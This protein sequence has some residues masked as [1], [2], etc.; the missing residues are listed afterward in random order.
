MSSRRSP[1]YKPLLLTTTMRNASRLRSFLA[2]LREFEGKVLTNRLCEEI[3]TELIR[4]GLYQPLIHSKKV[5]AKWESGEPLSLQEAL[6]VLSDNPQNHKEAGFDRGWPSR[7]DTHYKIAKWF[8]A[9]FYE[10]GSPITFSPLGVHCLEDDESIWERNFFTI[11]FANY[12]RSNPFQR[13]L[14]R[15]RPLLLLIETLSALREVEGSDSPGISRR[16]LPFLLCWQ[17]SYAADLASFILQIRESDGYDISD[18]RI[19]DICRGILEDPNY[20]IQPR[21][22]TADYSDEFL[23]K[24]RLTGLF[25]M[26]GHGRF[27]SLGKESKLD[28]INYLKANYSG[29]EDFVDE[30]SY[31]ESVSQFDETLLRLFHGDS[32]TPRSVIDDIQLDRWVLEF[33][34]ESIKSELALLARRRKSDDDLLRLIP[35]PLRLEFLSALRL[36]LEDKTLKVRPNYVSDDDGFPLSHAPGHNADIVVTNSAG[37]TYLLE[38]T[39]IT[40]GGQVRNEMVQITRHLQD[41]PSSRKTTL[42]VAPTIHTDTDRYVD[43]IFHRENLKILNQSIE[44]FASRPCLFSSE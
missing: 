20:T 4:L 12:Q 10:I 23:R 30:K 41:F 6:Q 19:L 3:E 43:W 21:S 42:F 25:V 39:L 38:V 34:A 26:R 5:A 8:G 7:F 31:F 2:V 11:A 17:N 18:E 14:N 33:G 28:A 35:N 37:E 40:G 36:R 44:D 1:K 32:S 27:I 24:V 16:E 29:S 22:L 15:N 13:V 9:A